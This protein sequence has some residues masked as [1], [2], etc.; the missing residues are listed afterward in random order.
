MAILQGKCIV[1]ATVLCMQLGILF[2]SPIPHENN[3]TVDSTLATGDSD[4][5]RNRDNTARSNLTV[6][7]VDIPAN[8]CGLV[9][10]QPNRVNMSLSL[11]TTT[12]AR[13]AAGVRREIAHVLNQVSIHKLIFNDV[14]ETYYI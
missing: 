11:A 3:Y 1:L 2:T 6:K 12:V 7:P 9:D 10:G 5:L 14:H 13:Q 8:P 4:T